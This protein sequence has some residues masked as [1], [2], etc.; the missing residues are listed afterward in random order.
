MSVFAAAQQGRRELL[1]AMRDQIAQ[2]LDEGVAA[3][4]LA[5]LSRRLM[6]IDHELEQVTAEEEGDAIGE[7]AQTPDAP[8]PTA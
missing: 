3:R 7:A 2:R 8:W 5:S 1:I 6:E 4:D